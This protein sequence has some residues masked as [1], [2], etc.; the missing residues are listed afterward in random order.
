MKSKV[1]L[2]AIFVTF[3]TLASFGQTNEELA[4]EKGR[5]GI[6]LMDMG[7][8]A[9]AIDLLEE[10]Q[11]LDAK[12]IHYPYEI[13]LA[14]YIDGKYDK[15][16]AILSKLLKHKDIHAQIY[17]M[18]G[19]S[20]SMKGE[21]GKAI[22][23]YDD[24]LKKFP[25]SGI[26]H[27]ERGNM[28]MFIDE[29][30]KALG[31][32]EKGIEADPAFPS[33]YYWAAKLLCGSSRKV[34]GVI[35]GE[36]FMN[37]ERGSKRTEEISKLLFDTYKSAI[38]INGDSTNISFSKSNTIY[39]NPKDLTSFKMPFGLMVYEPTM[40]IAILD[41]KEI[42]LESL[43]RIR[44]RFVEQ[45]YSQEHNKR[46]PNALFDYQHKV[47]QAGHIDAYNHWILMEGDS[48][49]FEAWYLDHREEWD[50]FMEWFAENPISIGRDNRFYRGQY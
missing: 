39:V 47:L 27:L 12:S 41:E 8:T 22:K 46:Y 10:A 50:A 15:S 49:A 11:K 13:A 29:L 7:M 3:T 16:I 34:W 37:L 48:A 35:Y 44:T 28:E 25:N 14:N 18:L 6:R 24:G 2:T 30:N 19:N 45:Y 33:N 26:L 20:Y 42:D 31:Y 4:L 40:A 21:R 32:Y 23:A 9:A 17:Q 43:S 38:T 5:E 36:L 1:I